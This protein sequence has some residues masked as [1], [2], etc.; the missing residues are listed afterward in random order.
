MEK[1]R[2]SL[3]EKPLS[4]MTVYVPDGLRESIRAACRDQ[5]ISVANFIRLSLEHALRD[6]SV[7]TGL[8]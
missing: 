5:H 7:R 3:Y 4:R 6:H 1:G 2:P 8:R